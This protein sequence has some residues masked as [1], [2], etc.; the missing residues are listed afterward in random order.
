MEGVRQRTRTGMNEFMQLL[1]ERIKTMGLPPSPLRRMRG[2]V[3]GADKYR[4]K[5]RLEA[6][7]KEQED[8]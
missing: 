8:K 1:G 7:W 2:Q 5:C 6:V 4:A 3:R